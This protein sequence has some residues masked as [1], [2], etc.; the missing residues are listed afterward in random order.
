M[1]VVSKKSVFAS[2]FLALVCSCH[3]PDD[4]LQIQ[5]KKMIG[6]EIRLNNQVKEIQ[7][8]Y[9]KVKIVS[10]INGN[11]M[12]CIYKLSLWTPFIA[13][14]EKEYGVPV[15]FFVAVSDTFL[16][17][18]TLDEIHFTHPVIIDY[19]DDFQKDNSLPGN[20]ILHTMLL[21]S[22]NKVS[23][24]GTPINNEPLQKLY[25]ERIEELLKK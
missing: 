21:D 10:R 1:K 18:K 4:R 3:K 24:V 5:V 23:L 20:S 6:R 16:L 13:K 7:A 15:L 8:N 12:P 9:T 22:T 11:C 2:L 17:R 25:I 14:L 19:N